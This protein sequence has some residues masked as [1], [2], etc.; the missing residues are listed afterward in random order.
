MRIIS[1]VLFGL[2]LLALSDRSFSVQIDDSSDLYRQVLKSIVAF[3]RPKRFA[4]WNQTIRA[5]LILAY[6]VP[7]QDPEGQFANIP[8]VYPALE[9]SLLYANLPNRSGR[10]FVYPDTV[11]KQFDVNEPGT[12][13][14]GFLG[15]SDMLREDTTADA[16]PTKSRLCEI[17]FSKIGFA[18]RWRAALVYAETCL[19]GTD[20]VCG[21]DAFL[22]VR[23]NSRNAQ[24][25]LKRK[26]FLWQGDPE[27]FWKY[28][29]AKEKP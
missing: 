14:A 20:G 17:G 22:F 12:E 21:G 11:L 10:D 3:E 19:A 15:T 26:S 25:R 5:D 23:K 6:R 18:N 29:R 7:R 8:G 1:A 13:F 2:A 27:Q 24:W 16:Q 28:Q 9:L 4:V